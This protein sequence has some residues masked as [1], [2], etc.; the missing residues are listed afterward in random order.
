MIDPK[1]ILDKHPGSVPRYT[2]YPTA[3]HFQ[4]DQGPQM[5][6][7]LI[8]GL[9][10]RQPISLYAHIPFCDRLCWFCGCH[11][12]HTKQYAPVSTYVGFLAREMALVAE[13]SGKSIPVS[14]VHFGGGSPSM[15]RSQDAIRLGYALRD[16]FLLTDKTEISVEIDP[17][18]VSGDTLAGLNE[19]G[20]TRA[21]LGVQDF[22]PKVQKAINRPQTFEQTE[23]VIRSLR[24]V[25]VGSLNIDVLYGLPYQT[26]ATMSDTINKVIELD[27][28]RI[29]LFGYAHVPWMKKHQQMIPTEALPD[30]QERFRQA[31]HA[32]ELLK[33]AGYVAIGID[34]FAKPNDAM[35]KAAASGRLRRNFQGYTTDECSTLLG[36][37]GS[38]ISRFDG[39]YI[40][41]V[42]PTAQYQQAISEGR[43]PA[44]KGMALSTDDLIRGFIIERLMC[45]FE[46]RFGDLERRFGGLAGPYLAEAKL[47]AKSDNDGLCGMVGDTFV[48]PENARP[49]ARIVAS[50]FDAYMAETKHRY[51]VA[52]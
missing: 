46:L 26:I 41:N 37:G 44:N 43:L 9:S 20:I 18:D 13:R 3:P 4:P 12:K 39:G 29:A 52:V 28:D 32:E 51:S 5:M 30:T 19:L 11:T 42:L 1:A 31:R 7:A 21:S 17:S 15:L 49:F 8:D 25:G 36:L 34:H 45:D 2:S 40:Q 27:P 23:T 50:W 10:S 47:L 22:D 38:S 33:E 16:N 24:D 48:I 14:Q 35:A 6:G